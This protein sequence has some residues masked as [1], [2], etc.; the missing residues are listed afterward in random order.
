VTEAIQPTAAPPPRRPLV[1]GVVN[2]TPDSFS[3]G[4]EWFDPEAG[5]AHGLELWA[6]GARIL[7][8][9]GE[10]TR[11]GAERPSVAEELRRVIPVISALVA[12]G[13]LVSV[14]TMRAVV[15]ERALAAGAAIVND[16]SGGLADEAMAPVVAAAGVPFVAMHWRGHSADMQSRASYADVVAEVVAELTARR[17]ALLD[18]G[19]DDDDLILDP[20]IGFAKTAAHNWALLRGIDRLQ[21]LG[22]RLLLGTSRK[23]FLGAV[24]RARGEERAPLARDVATAV[25]SAYA[26]QHGVWGVRVHNVIGTVDALDVAEQLWEGSHG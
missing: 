14:D 15:A 9:G 4:G 23:T 19:I 17:D 1:M 26:A 6:Q 24:G 11:P 20:G 16:V 25:T 2:V 13:C 18:A 22:H 5:I 7:D 12:A 3:D 21:G 8:V 10:S